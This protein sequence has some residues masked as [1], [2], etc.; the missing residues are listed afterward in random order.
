MTCALVQVTRAEFVL[1]WATYLAIMFSSLEAGI[2]IGIILATFYFAFSYARVRPPQLCSSTP[3]QSC[4][5]WHRMPRSRD[6]VASLHALPNDA[7]FR[8]RRTL[9]AMAAEPLVNSALYTIFRLR[10]CCQR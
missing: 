2:G 6:L 4:S 3:S 7:G 1:L 8:Q 9:S 10:A 5:P